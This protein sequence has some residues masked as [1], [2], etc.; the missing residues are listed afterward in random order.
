MIAGIALLGVVTAT[1][2]SWI[3]DRVA[4]QDELSHVATRRKVTELTEQVTELKQVLMQ[5]AA[6]FAATSGTP[7]PTL[8]EAINA[9]GS[10]KGPEA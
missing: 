8:P 7:A 2:A 4:A 6:Q 10:R 1:L 3:V 9:A 5:H